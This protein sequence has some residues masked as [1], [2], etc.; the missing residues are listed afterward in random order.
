MNTKTRCKLLT[1]QHTG[2]ERKLD[3]FPRL[4]SSTSAKIQR[5][6]MDTGTYDRIYIYDNQTLTLQDYTDFMRRAK[7]KEYQKH[8]GHQRCGKYLDVLDY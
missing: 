1:S 4:R 2:S 8:N 5:H 3:M 7:W 6:S